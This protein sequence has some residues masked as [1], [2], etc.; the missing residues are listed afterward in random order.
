MR[1]IAAWL[2]ISA[3]AVSPLLLAGDSAS[4]G[5][6]VIAGEL[7]VEP[8]TLIALG[9]E[10]YMEGDANRNASVRIEYR[11]KG[12]NTWKEGLPPLRLNG[13]RAVTNMMDGASRL[14]EG[15]TRFVKV[16]PPGSL[17]FNYV[18]PNMFAGS[19]FDLEPDTEYECRLTLTDPDGAAGQTIRVFTV[20]TRA[21]P[22][23]AEGG[24]TY[25]VYPFGYTG[26]REEPSFDG[27]MSAY[28]EASIGGS[29]YNAFVP[30]VKPGDTILVHAGLYK[31]ETP[32]N[33]AHEVS[34]QY[35]ECCNNTW[36]TPYY[37]TQN[38]T[39]DKPIAIKA[40]GDGE[41]IFDGNGNRVLF[42]VTAADYTYFEGITFRNTDIAIVGGR[43]RIVGS[44]GLTVKHCRFENIGMGVEADYSGSTNYYIADNVFIGRN[45]PNE[46]IS[47]YR[48]GRVWGSFWKGKPDSEFLEKSAA[49]SL[50]AV[51]FY[52][53]GTVI[54]FNKISGF[55]DGIDHSVYG[56]PDNWP[57]TPRERLPVAIDIYNNDI[58]NTHDNCIETS[59][60]LYNVRVLRNRCVNNA[61]PAFGP[62]PSLGGPHYFVRNIVYNDPDAPALAFW[63]SA[64]GAL[65]YQNTFL[66]GLGS[67]GDSSRQSDNNNGLF[68][69]AMVIASASNVH[70]RNNLILE[71]Y[72]DK[73]IFD[74]NTFDTYSS[75]DYNGFG[76]GPSSKIQF[77]WIKPDNGKATVLLDDQRKQFDYPTL[78]AWQRGTGQ[79]RH[80]VLVTYHVFKNLSPIDLTTPTRVYDPSTLDFSLNPHG[81]AVDAGMILPG[82]TDG[83][84]GKAPDLGALELGKPVPHYG[85]R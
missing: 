48:R 59:G 60:A 18:A 22:R 7:I 61:D 13:E 24:A 6:G 76:I 81:A 27:L 55:H 73:S 56:S 20:R 21:E 1:C 57:N 16:A 11:K 3:L 36:A 72:P 34:S 65:V 23:P 66:T 75:S 68:P 35:K 42:D 46:L 12:E 19:V 33:Y 63:A 38:G 78:R 14:R 2:G 30:R 40:A 37:L 43:K 41:V 54:A 51:L 80:S 82:I 29:W 5:G 9:F 39:S 84:T 17:A 71:S 62:F 15:Q 28:N 32:H 79:D 53:Q 83:Y 8:A 52:G 74:L 67:E 58:S 64:S 47:W 25:H 49:L 4:G 69:S 85:P 50:D 70:F 77:R 26:P 10:W 31:D 44:K 45:D